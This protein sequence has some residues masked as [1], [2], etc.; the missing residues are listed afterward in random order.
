MREGSL[1][2]PMRHPLDWQ[3]PDFTDAE[4]L[5]EEYVRFLEDYS[6]WFCYYMKHDDVFDFGNEAYIRRG[7]ELVAEIA[8]KRYFRSEPMN[9][10]IFRQLVGLR[11]LAFRLGARINMKELTEQ[12]SQGVFF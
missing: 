12:E 4:K 10:W 9:I 8:K 5:D 11:G 6:T 2:A 3:S 7:I 1:D